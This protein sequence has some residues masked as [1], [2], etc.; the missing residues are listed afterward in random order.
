MQES[1]KKIEYENSRDIQLF[2]K[3]VTTV[4]EG[5]LTPKIDFPID[6]FGMKFQTYLLTSTMEYAISL[7]ELSKNYICFYIW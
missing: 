6:I 4:L 7:E 2:S 5:K 3:T 1:L